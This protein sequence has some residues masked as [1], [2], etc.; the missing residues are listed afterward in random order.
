MPGGACCE[1]CTASNHSN[2]IKISWETI[3][4]VVID[5]RQKIVEEE[6]GVEKLEEQEAELEEKKQLL[7]KHLHKMCNN[8]IACCCKICCLQKILKLAKN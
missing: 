1:R 8:C 5:M 6:D 2:C 3:D 4:R 7:Q